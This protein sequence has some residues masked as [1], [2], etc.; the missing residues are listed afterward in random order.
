VSNARRAV[1][2][3]PTQRGQAVKGRGYTQRDPNPSTATPKS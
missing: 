1:G 3:Q 2:T